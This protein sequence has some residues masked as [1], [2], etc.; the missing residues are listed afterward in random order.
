MTISFVVGI[1]IIRL[2]K[3][4]V[5]H[6]LLCLIIMSTDIIV[7]CVYCPEYMHVIYFHDHLLRGGNRHNQAQ[8]DQGLSHS[9]MP[10][11][12]VY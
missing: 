4:K 2:R 3:T 9:S 12:Y 11:N 1:V 7:W 6:I 8:E 5:C 10:D